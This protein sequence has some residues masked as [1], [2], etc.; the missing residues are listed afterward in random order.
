VQ[1]IADFEGKRV[2]WNNML[3]I[4]TDKGDRGLETPIERNA[5]FWHRAC[6]TRIF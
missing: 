4:V 1:R 6:Y 5:K 3:N 2:S